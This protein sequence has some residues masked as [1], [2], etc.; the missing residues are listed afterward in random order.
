LRS[1]QAKA[2]ENRKPTINTCSI[3]WILLLLP[4]YKFRQIHI[5]NVYAVVA[6]GIATGRRIKKRKR[7]F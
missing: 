6:T 3:R 5:L 4:G 7:V 1:L 2:T